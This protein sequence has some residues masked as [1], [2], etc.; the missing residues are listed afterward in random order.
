M[1]FVYMLK[2]NKDNEFYYGFTNNLE[3]RLKE[4]NN[5]DKEWRLLYYE[6]YLSERDAR[7]R[8]KTLKHYGQS[9]SHLKRRLRESLNL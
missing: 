1:Y 5:I 2:D 4:H 7:Q 9:R 8:E 3:R 6:A